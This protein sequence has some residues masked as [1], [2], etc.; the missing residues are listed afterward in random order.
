MKSG[1]FCFTSP[2]K[3]NFIKKG[4]PHPFILYI[5]GVCFKFT[6]VIKLR[7]VQ[8][9]VKNMKEKP[10]FVLDGML[11]G[12]CRWLKFLGFSARI[13]NNPKQLPSSLIPDKKTIFLTRTPKHYIDNEDIICFVLTSDQI[14][15][16]LEELNKAFQIF[17]KI[18]FLSRCS[19]CDVPIEPVKKWTI[20]DKIPEKVWKSYDQFWR[21]PACERI[22]WEGGHVKRMK[23]KLRLMGV[24]LENNK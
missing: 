11:A 7:S 20:K 19:L 17:N 1:S 24:P 16:Q 13:V 22:Y 4:K 23:E 5:L 18:D 15:E 3:K 10:N 6:V 14:P 2:L 21:C 12:L 9:T 8:M